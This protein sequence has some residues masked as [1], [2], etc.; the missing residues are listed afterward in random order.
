MKHLSQLSYLLSNSGLARYFLFKDNRRNYFLSFLSSLPSVTI[1]K[2]MDVECPTVVDGVVP[3]ICP[4]YL[5][6]RC[7]F[8]ERCRNLHPVELGPSCPSSLTC[9]SSVKRENGSN[10]EDQPK[11]LRMRTAS[12]AIHRIMWDPALNAGDFLVVYL[13]RFTGP[14]SIPLTEYVSL[15]IDGVFTIP[16]HRI[17]QIQFRSSESSISHIVWDKQSRTDHVF[18]NTDGKTLFDIIRSVKEPMN[19]LNTTCCD[20][21]PLDGLNRSPNEIN[22]DLVIQ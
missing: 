18:A 6:N 3:I 19:L 15:D 12:D 14:E 20:L 8:A 2:K 22:G 10:S 17:Q 16:Q 4:F 21:R 7:R 5:E 1:E 9:L 13:D 11:R